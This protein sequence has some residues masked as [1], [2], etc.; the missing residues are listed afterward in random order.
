MPDLSLHHITCHLTHLID[1]NTHGQDK[2]WVQLEQ[3]QSPI[4]LKSLPLFRQSI[5]QNLKFHSLI[6]TTLLV[7]LKAFTKHNLL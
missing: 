2:A 5:P 3:I 1:W 4:L 6:S 7:C